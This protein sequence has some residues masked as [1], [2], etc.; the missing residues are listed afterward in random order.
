MAN[1]LQET[2]NL[3]NELGLE[4]ENIIFIGS[5][6]S[7]YACDWT[8]FYELANQEYSSGFGWQEVA[9]DLEIV[10]KDGTRFQR[11]EYDGSENWNVQEPFVIPTE[12]KPIRKLINR[13]DGWQS[14]AAMHEDLEP[15]KEQ[16]S[17]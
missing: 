7:G 16:L 9:S 1:L 10:F 12:T 2:Q 14:L 15:I 17:E 8:T 13:N 4:I 5:T 11:H 3:I 6:S